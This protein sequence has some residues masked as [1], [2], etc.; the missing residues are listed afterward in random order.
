[1]LEK[2]APSN[3]VQFFILS[4]R[5]PASEPLGNSGKV[6]HEVLQRLRVLE[7]AQKVG[8]RGQTQVI[9][10]ERS[11]EDVTLCRLTGDCRARSDPLGTGIFGVT[12]RFSARS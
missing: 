4:L 10:Q 2:V 9:R 5:K 12:D 3:R 6:S 11:H 8:D 7:R 1:M